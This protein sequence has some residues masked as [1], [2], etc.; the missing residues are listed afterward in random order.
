MSSRG[1]V[2]ASS[3]VKAS[4]DLSVKTNLVGIIRFPS[5]T[6]ESGMISLTLKRDHKSSDT[7]YFNIKRNSHSDQDKK[8]CYPI[9]NNQ[10]AR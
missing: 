6:S 7:N 5:G 8:K 1:S 4:L 3:H 10:A 9:R 2:R